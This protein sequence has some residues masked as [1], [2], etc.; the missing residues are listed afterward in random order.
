M[1]ESDFP[2]AGRH[3]PRPT[4]LETNALLVNTP[5]HVLHC[6]RDD[7]THMGVCNQHHPRMWLEF[8][9][10]S[11]ALEI[12][13]KFR[14]GA[15]VPTVLCNRIVDDRSLCATG[16]QH[17]NNFEQP[18]SSHVT[19]TFAT[20]SR[21]NPLKSTRE[22]QTRKMGRQQINLGRQWWGDL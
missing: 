5:H 16:E 8:T 13:G 1:L 10:N 14:G 19:F 15:K 9:R 12:S 2:S 6:R 22:T 11:G 7:R 21:F 20:G 4:D 18:P 3:G 17:Q